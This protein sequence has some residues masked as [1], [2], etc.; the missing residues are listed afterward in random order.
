VRRAALVLATLALATLALA[1]RADGFVYWANDFGTIASANLDGTTA[2]PNLVSVGGQVH[3]LAV[4]SG[5]IYWT[6]FNTNTI[7]RAKPRR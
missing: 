5:H 6:N 4:D 7:G 2:N 1:A 3:G